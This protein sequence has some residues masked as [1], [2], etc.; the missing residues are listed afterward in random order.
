[1]TA[2]TMRMV[3]PISMVPILHRAA[4]LQRC[5]TSFGVEGQLPVPTYDKV[6]ALVRDVQN[7]R[8][9]LSRTEFLEHFQAICAGTPKPRG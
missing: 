2:I 9:C 1:M 5:A 4:R 8:L 7:R 3:R 6:I